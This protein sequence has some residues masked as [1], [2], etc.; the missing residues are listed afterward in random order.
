M[1]TKYGD[2]TNSELQ[3]ILDVTPVETPHYQKA[4]DEM[5]RRIARRSPN[6]ARIGLLFSA[7]A[8]FATV[9]VNA[10]KIVDF[11]RGLFK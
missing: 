1:S 11:F 3:H 7:L 10:G 4:R 2:L 9:A 6:I 8:A 5:T